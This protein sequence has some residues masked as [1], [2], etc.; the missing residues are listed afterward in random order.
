MPPD[1]VLLTSPDLSLDGIKFTDTLQGFR[2]ISVGALA[3]TSWIFLRAWAN[4]RLLLFCWIRTTPGNHRKHGLKHTAVTGQM[5]LWMDTFPVGLYANQT[6]GGI[7]EPALRSSQRRPT[8]WLSGFYHYPAPGPE[9][10]IIGMYLTGHQHILA[11]DVI[12]GSSSSATAPVQR[13]SM[14]RLIPRPGDGI[15]LTGGIMADGL[16]LPGDNMSQKPRSGITACNGF[17]GAGACTI[18]SHRQQASF[19]RLF[20]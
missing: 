12:S 3:C 16:H 20:Q 2:V 7:C 6:A 19:G 4:T 17:E 1:A 14:A 10:D 15:F 5:I 13:P 18:W 8:T 11:Q 9:G